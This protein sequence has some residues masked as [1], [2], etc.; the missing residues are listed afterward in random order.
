MGE[1]KLKGIAGGKILISDEIQEIIL[2][3]CNQR[4]STRKF[5]IS[6]MV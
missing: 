1:K 2:I 3:R 6:L 5:D 4:K